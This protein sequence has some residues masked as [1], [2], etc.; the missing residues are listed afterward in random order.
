MSELL[1]N[2]AVIGA[3]K[4]GLAAFILLMVWRL[5]DEDRLTERLGS[6]DLAWIL[7]ALIITIPQTILSALR[8]RWV[9]AI[10]GDDIPPGAAI[11]EYYIATFLN[12]VLPGGIGGEVVRVVRRGHSLKSDDQQNGGYKQAFW[13]VFLERA[14]GQI[15]MVLACLPALTLISEIAFYFGCVLFVAI[16]IAG[17]FFGRRH[18]ATPGNT[19]RLAI[20]SVAI[21]VSYIVVFWC[22]VAALGITLDPLLA[23]I[24]LAPALLTMALPI[25]PAGWGLREAASAAL[26]GF[27]GLGVTDG[28]AASITYGLVILIAALPGLVLVLMR[29]RS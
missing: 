11:R 19:A 18:I 3:L 2:K 7:L 25:T 5:V 17:V 6:V 29:R 21:V 14:L 26:W 22:C 9:A 12:Q 10:I 1:R 23:L 16:V 20:S 13:G 15:V 28:V 8:W 24:V 27:A 4:I